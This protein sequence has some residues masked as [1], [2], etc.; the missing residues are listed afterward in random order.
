MDYGGNRAVCR[1][2]THILDTPSH[3]AAAC[4]LLDQLTTVVTLLG[5]CLLTVHLVCRFRAAS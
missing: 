4:C 1:T 2:W 5:V 3:L